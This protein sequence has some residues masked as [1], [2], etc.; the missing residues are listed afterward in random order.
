MVPVA[1]RAV[2]VPH[3]RALLSRTLT[4]V[5]S[6]PASVVFAADSTPRV[7]FGDWRSL[8]GRTPRPLAFLVAS[9]APLIPAP[10]GQSTPFA[11]TAATRPREGTSTYNPD[12]V[13]SSSASRDVAFDAAAGET[14]APAGLAVARTSAPVRP[15]TLARPRHWHER[16]ALAR[17][18]LVPCGTGCVPRCSAGNFCFPHLD[19]RTPASRRF[20]LVPAPL[21]ACARTA[22]DVSVVS[23]G[24]EPGRVAF[25]DASS[26]R[27]M[28]R[29][30]TWRCLPGPAA[31]SNLRP[32]VDGSGA[33][34]SAA[35][36]AAFPTRPVKSA[37]LP[38][39][40]DLPASSDRSPV[41]RR[42][43]TASRT[44]HRPIH[45][46]PF[47]PFGA[48]SLATPGRAQD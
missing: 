42:T 2:S 43:R 17:P 46:R 1:V 47:A 14:R 5:D 25:H 13:P 19:T 18:A 27:R 15:C 22:R 12:R 4:S 28:T 20:P 35:D 24:N 39:L 11:R 7:A 29:L 34:A 37:P 48:T 45:D 9:N 23:P 32:S 6:A 44:R 30:R 41:F 38:Q 36:Q 16:F 3:G 31:P 8:T 33:F 21:R 40:D 10:T 26:L